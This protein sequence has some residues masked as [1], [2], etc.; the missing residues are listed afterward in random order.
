LSPLL[1]FGLLTG[2]DV[3]VGHSGRP[4]Q[5]DRTHIVAGFNPDQYAASV[6]IAERQS[7]DG[8]V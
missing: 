8:A 4:H 6:N 7:K 3:A 2:G 5:R 1:H